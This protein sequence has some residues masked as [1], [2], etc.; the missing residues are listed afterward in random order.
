MYKEFSDSKNTGCSPI[1]KLEALIKEKGQ[2]YKCG[3]NGCGLS[4]GEKQRISI[5]RSLLKHASVLLVDEATASLD[6]ESAYEIVS[7]ILEIRD[8]TRVVVTHSLE[9]A[10]LKRYDQIITMKDGR[11]V[12][13]GKFEELM[14]KREYFYALY[15]V[16]K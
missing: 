2:L 5:A 9:E 6:R 1:G 16:A 3:E 10:L 11:I 12:E 15:T 7:D 8:V 14:E 13:Q 4:G